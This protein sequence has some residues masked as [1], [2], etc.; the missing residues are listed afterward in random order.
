MTSVPLSLTAVLALSLATT[1]CKKKEEGGGDKAAKPGETA[2][3]GGAPPPAA[4]LE[5]KKL[6]GLGVEVEA[7]SDATVDDNT[8]NAGFP[9]ATI[10]AS[11]TTFVHGAG[12][13]SPLKPDLDGAKAEIQKDP[14]PFKQFTKEEKSDT[15]WHLEY[16][17]SSM[18]DKAETLYGVSIRTTI[19]GKPFEC[20]SNARSTAER[21]NVVRLCKSLR[22][23]Q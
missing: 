23:A 13:M 9:T 17:L 4:K 10:W 7:P 6:G 3:P 5:W 15:G 14:N 12:D 16:E 21:D 2:K 11:P 19:D 20:G 22:K 8:A 1:G 18:I